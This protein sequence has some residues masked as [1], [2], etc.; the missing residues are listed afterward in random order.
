MSAEGPN[1]AAQPSPLPGP[2]G[3]LSLEIC[4]QPDRANIP[5]RSPQASL[6]LK[7]PTVV[8]GRLGS[9]ASMFC[10]ASE[11][12]SYIHW[13][14]HQEGSAPKRILM[15]NMQRSQ[16]QRYGGYRSDKIT[17]KKVGGSNRC[18]L[19]LL[20]L[21]KRDEGT[22]YCAAWEAHSHE[23]LGSGPSL[24]TRNKNPDEDISP[25]PTIFLP[26]I[27][28]VKLHKA[29]TYVCLLE[30]IFPD[31][32][33]IDWKEKN[34]KTVLDSLQGNTMKTK[35]MYMKY[36]W[37]TVYEESMDR[38]HKCIVKHEK[39]GKSVEQ[40]ILFPSINKGMS[41][42]CN[43]ANEGISVK[44]TL[45]ETKQWLLLDPLQLQFMNTSAYYTYLLLLVKSVVYTIIIAIGLLGR[46]VLHDNG[47]PS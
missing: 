40:E 46:A 38:E 3:H 5:P 43:K 35:D 18:E 16:D 37:L 12:V 6:S 17:A 42:H 28:E 32:I 25:K 41:S 15:L 2:S 36:T 8:V 33:E 23:I 9:S 14:L 24:V 11:S 10:T 1:P 22:Y 34:G 30:N 19:S 45:G 27:A 47:K 39:K 29:G 26:S 21:E 4:L 7:Q 44:A 13:Y 31:V 20:K